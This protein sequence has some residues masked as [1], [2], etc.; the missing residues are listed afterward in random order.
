M[1]SASSVEEPQPGMISASSVEES[2]P[3]MIAANSVEV[4]KEEYDIGE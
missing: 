2:Q 4:L 3:G 1:I